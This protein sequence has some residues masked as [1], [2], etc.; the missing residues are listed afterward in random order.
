MKRV[1]TT[2]KKSVPEAMA[3]HTLTSRWLANV[4]DVVAVRRGST[5]SLH[6]CHPLLGA[7]DSTIPPYTRKKKQN[8]AL[9]DF[10]SA[11]QLSV[12]PVGR[13]FPTAQG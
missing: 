5:L 1:R 12:N 6:H 8:C 11:Q 2:G 9:G 7:E 13:P 4:W 10:D 3:K